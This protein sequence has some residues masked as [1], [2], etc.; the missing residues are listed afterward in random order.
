VPK[1]PTDLTQ[2][3]L[4]VERGL[5][6]ERP[7]LNDAVMARAFYDYEG[8]R[9]ATLFMRD[10]ETTFDFLG[11]PYRPSGFVREVVDVLTEHLYAP[12]PT[13]QWSDDAGQELLDRVYQDNHI[14]SLM[15]R[16]DQLSTLADVCA[17]QVDAMEGEFAER[18]L[19]LNLWE[20]GEFTAWTDPNNAREVVAVCTIDRFDQ[21]TRY[22]LWNAAEVWTYLTKKGDGTAGGRVADLQSKEPHDYGCVPFSFI[23]YDLPIQQFWA[24]GISELLVNAEIRLNDRLSRLDEAINKHLNPVATAT[25]VPSDWQ[26]VIEPL[27]FIK[28]RSTGGIGA[29]GGYEAG[30][31]PVL[32][33]LQAQIDTAGAW[34]DLTNYL[35][36]VLEALR[37]P[38]SSVRME[39]TGVA[40]GISLIVEQAPLLT[41]ARRRRYPFQVY[42]AS[43]AKTILTCAGTHYGIP[44]LVSSAKSGRL[45]LAW[46]KP[47]VPI[48]TAD[49]LELGIAEVQAG[50]KSLLMLVQD[51]YGVGREQAL[52]IMEQ[53]QEDQADAGKINPAIMKDAGTEADEE[54]EKQAA[55]NDPGA[56]GGD[57]VPSAGDGSS[58]YTKDAGKGPGQ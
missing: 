46:P 41:R 10:A 25:N 48:P 55:L 44:S 36:Q 39:Q 6:N 27:R 19:T 15:L 56:K 2:Y 32:A 3:G 22:R 33:Y 49:V 5:Q 50:L 38:A 28:L 37:V 20:A 13:R 52:Q 31:D 29:T 45:A 7:R 53:I 17:I 30:K 11:R 9:Y 42:E 1:Q 14:D 16:C 57:P 54:A 23:H 43:L 26:P 12:G 21:Q 40:S 51:W 18:P 24:A 34:L 58:S 8:R 35:N 4:E 47:S